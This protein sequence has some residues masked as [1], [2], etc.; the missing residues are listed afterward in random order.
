LQEPIS[1]VSI[2]N[3]DRVSHHFLQTDGRVSAFLPIASH[4]VLE[5]FGREG[6]CAIELARA[7]HLPFCV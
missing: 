5:A 7:C 6:I 4:L 3:S 2:P 1:A